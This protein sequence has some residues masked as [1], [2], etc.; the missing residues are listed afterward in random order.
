MIKVVV[1]EDLDSYRNVLEILLNGSEGFVCNGA[2]QNA[3]A[4]LKRIPELKP[5]VA[6]IDIY[7]PG[8]NGIELF[9]S[10]R[11]DPATRDIPVIFST[12]YPTRLRTELPDLE[13]M[14]AELLPKPFDIYDLEHRVAAKLV[15]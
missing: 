7:L 5:D 2:F 8:M 15:A 13:T 4:A 14:G 11:A 1:I 9:H 6:I 12:A 10:L 3:E